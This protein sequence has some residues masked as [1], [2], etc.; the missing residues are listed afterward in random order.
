WIKEVNGG[1][2]VTGCGAGASP[3]QPLCDAANS[4]CTNTDNTTEA[5]RYE[6]QLGEILRAAKIR[7]PNLKMAFLASRIYGGYAP[8]TTNPPPV[9]PEPYAYEYGYSVKWEIQ[10]QTNQIRTGTVDRVARDLNYNNG[11]V[12][13]I[14]WGPYLWANGTNPRSDGLV[15]CDGQAGAP[16]NGEIDFQSDGTHPNAQG[17]GKVSNLLMCLRHIPLGFET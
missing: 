10:A 8:L 6:S 12:P 2:Q 3:W 17:I 13:W 16:C 5:L 9:S 11:T 14:A 1:P 4:G 7:W 15:W